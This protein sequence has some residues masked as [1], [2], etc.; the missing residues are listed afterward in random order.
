M[1][2]LFIND[3]GINESFKRYYQQFEEDK[4]DTRRYETIHPDLGKINKIL[5]QRDQLVVLCGEMITTLS[6]PQNQEHMFEG[7]AK[8]NFLKMLNLWNKDFREYSGEVK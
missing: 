2:N 3:N 7:E 6:L 5:K 1:T 8:N 4:G